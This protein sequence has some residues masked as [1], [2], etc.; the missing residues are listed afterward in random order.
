MKNIDSKYRFL[1]AGGGTGGHIFPIIAVAEKVRELLPNS[2]ILFVGTANKIESEV[3]PK[4]GFNY[5]SIWISGF[6]RGEVFQ[7][8]MLLLKVPIS[9]IQSFMIV[10]KL[11]PGVAV[12]SGAYVSAPIIKVAAL[13]GSK[14]VLLEQNYLPGISNKLLQN[15]ASEIHTTFEE[16]IKFFK[17]KSKVR[18]TG[19]PIRSELKLID[20]NEAKVKLG[21]N[22]AAKLILV[23]GGSGG[24]FFINETIKK[25]LPQLVSLKI[26][27]N[28][29]T[30]NR[31]YE[32]YKLAG[33]ESVKIYPFFEN[34]V[35]VYS[36]AD[37]VIAR[38]GS[39]TLTELSVLGLPTILVPS[40]NVAGDHQR[41]NARSLEEKNAV[42][43]IEEKDL[44][45]NLFEL[46]SNTISN[47]EVLEELKEN[48]KH[49]AKKDAA[50]TIAKRVIELAGA[51]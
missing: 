5:K 1:F 43:V 31:Y 9:L 11:K 45:S 2:E 3:V 47:N 15:D 46:I 33:N 37:L 35:D 7:N 23:M 19:N 48:I 18:A 29:Q 28:W 21:F 8:L 49:F 24:S 22:P 30:G 13:T 42:E 50:E 6:I 4:A 38:A 41:K 51:A 26:Q 14:I 34:L 17:D 27:V 25:I 12:G 44:S 36:A 32:S 10:R 16:S 40:P 20:K 39:T